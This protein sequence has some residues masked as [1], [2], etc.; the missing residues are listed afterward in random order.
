M[1]SLYKH[2]KNS[3]LSSTDYLKIEYYKKTKKAKIVILASILAKRLLA[4]SAFLELRSRLNM[5]F[6]ILIKKK[7]LFLIK[8]EL[9]KTMLRKV[10]NLKMLK[11]KN[12]NIFLKNTIIKSSTLVFK[13]ILIKNLISFY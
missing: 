1:L 9:L 2:K 7:I 4:I 11:K 13:D 6:L 12:F 5:H 3:Y 8:N 10:V